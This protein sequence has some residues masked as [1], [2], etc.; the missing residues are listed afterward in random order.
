MIM[1][2]ILDA[3]TCKDILTVLGIG[4]VT[5]VIALVKKVLHTRISSGNGI[6]YVDLAVNLIVYLVGLVLLC[7]FT[8]S[9]LA[10]LF[11]TVETIFLYRN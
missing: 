3:L 7:G 6:S 5:T 10:N 1:S 4:S 8:F 9:V 11:H 2:A